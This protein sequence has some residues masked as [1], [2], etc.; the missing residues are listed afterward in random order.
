MASQKSRTKSLTSSSTRIATCYAFAEKYNITF[1]QLQLWNTGLHLTCDNLIKKNIMCIQGPAE[2]TGLT[3][4]TTNTD[5][6]LKPMATA[7]LPVVA[8]KDVKTLEAQ[9]T[10]T[11][12]MEA[13]NANPQSLPSGGNLFPN[14]IK[15]MALKSGGARSSSTASATTSDPQVLDTAPQVAQV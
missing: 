10:N 14:L 3:Q 12:K 9:N 15:D 8:P 11:A 13:A 7:N 2:T 4:E 6:S 5:T 1:E